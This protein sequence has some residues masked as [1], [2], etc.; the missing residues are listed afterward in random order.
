MPV[1][2][3]QEGK[4]FFQ[5]ARRRFHWSASS[6][7]LSLPDLASGLFGSQAMDWP[8]FAR[9]TRLFYGRSFMARCRFPPC[10]IAMAELNRPPGVA[11]SL[12][13]VPE[14]IFPTEELRS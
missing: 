4:V 13:A 12:K 1:R 14:P 11:C 8:V 6:A 10:M 3:S 2:R 9:L 7:V 5:G